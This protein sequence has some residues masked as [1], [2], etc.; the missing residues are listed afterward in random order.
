MMENPSIS[1]HPPF[2]TKYINVIVS[3]Y[4]ETVESVD[5]IIRNYEGRSIKTYGI[6]S[7]ISRNMRSILTE[8]IELIDDLNSY[9]PDNGFDIN[10]D[11]RG[12]WKVFFRLLRRIAFKL[13]FC[14]K[15][16][17]HIPD[18]EGFDEKLVRRHIQGFY[19]SY[20]LNLNTYFENILLI[21]INLR[22]ISTKGHLMNEEEVLDIAKVSIK[23]IWLDVCLFILFIIILTIYIYIYIYI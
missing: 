20:F 14:I 16:L 5:S 3:L 13:K 19:Y 21:V 7:S 15:N 8:L 11:H 23:P 2:L 1:S 12:G 9:K 4:E 18:N 10:I 17:P 22:K 6:L